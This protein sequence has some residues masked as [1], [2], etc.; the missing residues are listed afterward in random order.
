MEPK[1]TTT[2]GAEAVASLDDAATP[3][4]LPA[5]NVTE[6]APASESE[7]DRLRALLEEAKHNESQWKDVYLRALADHENYKKRTLR[8]QT[9]QVRFANERLLKEILPV[10]DN[11]ERALSHARPSAGQPAIH[12]EKIVEGVELVSKQLLATLGKFGVKPVDSL[13]QPF[14]PVLH[15]SVGQREV[16]T[17]ADCGCVVEEA[18]KGYLL[19]ERLLRPALVVVG[20]LPE[21]SEGQSAPAS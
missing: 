19:N 4:G 13:R 15:Q 7:V 14:D 21:I 5:E 17:E 12:R 9:D 20:K 6:P 8:D 16:T 3:G 2:D 11:L 1:E 10:M 18:Q